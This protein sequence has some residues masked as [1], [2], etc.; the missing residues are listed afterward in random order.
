[1]TIIGF[2]GSGNIGQAVAQA[3]IAAG[4]EVVM[5]NSRGPQTL[6]DVVAD[7][8]D[9]ASADTVDGAAERGEVVVV[10]IPLSAYREIPAGPLAGKVVIDT[11]NYYPQRDGQIAAL[12]DGSTTSSQLLADHL[13]ASHVVKAFNHVPAA[14]ITADAQPAGSPDRRALAIAG[15]EEG[16]KSTVTSLIDAVGF[17]VVDLGD[18]G[19]GRRVQPGTPAYGPRLD[20]R[21]LRAAT[22]DAG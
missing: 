22:E 10:T 4:H 12:D 14:D 11:N 1:M 6:D 5:S 16:A 15:D 8:G 21:A 9:A 3:V 19:E 18:L 20:A 17:D 13:P 2:I 7:L